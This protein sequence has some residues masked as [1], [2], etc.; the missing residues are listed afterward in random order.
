VKK[1]SRKRVLIGFLGVSAILVTLIVMVSSS[2]N[3]ATGSKVI[4]T[5]AENIVLEERDL[6]GGWV[7][8]NGIPIAEPGDD[9]LGYSIRFYN[10]TNSPVGASLVSV[11]ITYG[12]SENASKMYDVM[13]KSLTSAN[14]MEK[15]SLGVGERSDL[16]VLAGSGDF[17][18]EKYVIILEKNVFVMLGFGYNSSHIITDELVKEMAQIQYEKI[19]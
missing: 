13:K 1:N 16:I 5:S 12:R 18:N 9:H 14:Q 4:S 6:P 15:G 10:D 19:K 17:G 7:D 11:A 8:G 2:S 3:G